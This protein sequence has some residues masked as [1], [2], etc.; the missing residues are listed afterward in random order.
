MYPNFF[1]NCTLRHVSFENFTLAVAGFV[2]RNSN[3]YDVN[4]TNCHSLEP[5]NVTDYEYALI[6]ENLSILSGVN[7]KLDFKRE[8]LYNETF[9]SILGN[10]STITYENKKEYL[11]KGYE[12]SDL[13]GVSYIEKQ[14]EDI[15]KG[16][17]SKYKLEN[18]S[19]KLI[20]ELKLLLKDFS[21]DNDNLIISY[22]YVLNNEGEKI[23]LGTW[24]YDLDTN[25]IILISRDSAQALVGSNGLVLKQVLE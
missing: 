19:L 3:L 4:F 23:F 10:V 14:Y 18:G 15:L 22:C 21:Y 1:I 13:V 9:R 5:E 8:Y 24:G 25:E 12:L 2:I 20:S 17:K 7:I 6:A 11:S 16:T